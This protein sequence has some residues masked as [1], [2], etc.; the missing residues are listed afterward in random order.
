MHR[1]CLLVFIVLMLC[2]AAIAYAMTPTSYRIHDDKNFGRVSSAAPASDGKLLSNSV[3]DQR[4]DASRNAFWLATGNGINYWHITSA[5]SSMQSFV[6]G[7]AIGNGGVSAIVPTTRS[8]WAATAF[9]TTIKGE[10]FPAGGGIGY[11]TNDG[12]TWTWM[13]QPVDRRD[14]T[15]Y[16]PTSTV[17]YNIAYDLAVTD[18]AVWAACFGG[19]LRKFR[20]SDSTWSVVAPD[21]NEFSSGDY[22]NHRVFSV[23]AINDSVIWCGTAGGINLSQDGGNSWENFHFI[24]NNVQTLQGNFVVALHRQV[25]RTGREIIWAS[26]W[27]AEDPSEEY[28]LCW[29]DNLGASWNRTLE[30]VKI[31]NITSVDSVVYAVGP[32]GLF[33]S[34]DYGET[35]G[36]FPNM[37]DWR[38]NER[39]GETELYSVAIG[40]HRLSVGGP[41]GWATSNDL[42]GSWSIGRSFVSTTEAEQPSIYAYPNPFSP[43]RFGLVRFQY[44]LANSGNVTLTL[45][46]YAMEKAG[47]IIKNASRPAGDNTELWNGRFGSSTLANGV[48]FYRLEKPGGEFWGKIIILD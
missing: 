10:V 8:V 40:N 23:L 18:S 6:S 33:K 28:G 4:F 15:R 48:Y 22:L 1:N 13:H 9:D 16:K 26:T 29:S 44:N 38:G 25:T 19:G 27:K 45:F 24:P 12:I 3:I 39:F 46:N 41:D 32:D 2:L 14:E 7:V 36:N 5:D 21:T 30:G 37:I 17:V 43:Q 11:T 47:T 31:H 34:N 20:F 35:W 42:G